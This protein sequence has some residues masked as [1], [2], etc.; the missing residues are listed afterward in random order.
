MCFSPEWHI[1]E[2]KGKTDTTNQLLQN[3]QL[4]TLIEM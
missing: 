4:K 3:F 1:R 2:A